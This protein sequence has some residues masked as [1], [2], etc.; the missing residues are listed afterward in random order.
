MRKFRLTS[1]FFLSPS[2]RCTSTMIRSSDKSWSADE[3]APGALTRLV[4]F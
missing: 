3:E 2:P 4:Q 1:Y